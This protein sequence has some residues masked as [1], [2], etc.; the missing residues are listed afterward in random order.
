MDQVPKLSVLY[1]VVGRSK[2][3]Q[4]GDWHGTSE[5][6]LLILL[7]NALA[8]PFNSAS[9]GLSWLISSCLALQLLLFIYMGHVQSP[10]GIPF[11]F[12]ALQRAAVPQQT[13]LEADT[14]VCRQEQ[15]LAPRKCSAVPR[16]R[17]SRC[18]CP[19]NVLRHARGACLA[20]QLGAAC[21]SPSCTG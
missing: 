17:L 13:A 7:L 11:L 16:K 15:P 1:K 2:K 5:E 10:L 18:V 6:V 19:G 20:L 4:A 14:R 12:W 3:N 8:L 9:L 21:D